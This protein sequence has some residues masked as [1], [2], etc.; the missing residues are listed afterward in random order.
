MAKKSSIMANVTRE[1]EKL[2]N[3]KD[4]KDGNALNSGFILSA[5]ATKF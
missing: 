3:T 5:S 1:L 4:M 2:S